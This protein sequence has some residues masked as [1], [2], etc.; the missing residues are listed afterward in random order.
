MKLI[1]TILIILF[2]IY[3]IMSILEI[4]FKKRNNTFD[5][6]F[7]VPG[8]GKTTLAAYLAKKRLKKKK[9][10]Y[11]NVSIKGCYNI[12]K[13]DIGHY[14]M[15]HGLILCDEAGVEFN[16]RNYAKNFD[17]E[18]IEFLKHHRH[19]DNDLAFFSQYWN[20]IDVT[21][22]RLSTRLFLLKKSLIPFF[23]KRKKI[24]KRIGIDETTKQIIDEYY[25]VPFIFGNKYIFSPALWKM[26]DT[27]EKTKLPIKKFE[28]YGKG[29]EE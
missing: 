8:S 16:N 3:I 2:F 6:Y 5:T 12:N 4:I 28:I 20:D 11:S 26:F 18:Q 19:Y 15:S 25:F 14:D 13:S 10:V 7:G 21:L 1:F 17:Y 29:E 27:H 22:R 23:I 9:D 24:G